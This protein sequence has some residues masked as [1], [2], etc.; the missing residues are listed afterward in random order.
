VCV[1]IVCLTVIYM[2]I[3]LYNRLLGMLCVCDHCV[4]NCYL[5]DNHVILQAVRNAAV[6]LVGVIYMYMGPQFRTFFE[7]EKPAL[8]QQIDTEIEKVIP[9]NKFLT[10]FNK[11]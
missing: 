11:R 8:L 2:I 7:D 4:F 1:I 6:A 3:M 10:L 9:E 5:Y